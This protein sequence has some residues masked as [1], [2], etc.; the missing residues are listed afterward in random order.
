VLN[1]FGIAKIVEAKDGV[2]STGMSVGT[3]AYMA[4]EQ[5]EG[6]KGRIG[7]TSDLYS[8]GIILYEMVTGQPPFIADTPLAI[9]L[10]HLSDP[11]PLPRTLNPSLP[12]SIERVILKALARVPADR[13]QNGAHLVEALRQALV[14]APTSVETAAPTLAAPIEDKDQAQTVESAR[15]PGARAASPSLAE[16]TVTPAKKIE[17]FWWKAPLWVWG[18]IGGVF[19]LAVVGGILLVGNS[20]PFWSGSAGHITFGFD[21]RVYR[22]EAREEAILE[23][24]SQALDKLSPGAE[25][26]WLNL[27]PDGEWLLL[28]TDRF[29]PECDGWPCLAL[30]SGDLSAGDTIFV[31]WE[32]IHPHGFGAVAS[33]GNL[34]VF[35]RE[36]GPHETDMWALVRSN[37]DWNA[38]LLLTGDSPYTY[39]YWPAI[40]ADGN[41]VVFNCSEVLYGGEG[42]AICEAGTDGT[43]FRV[44]LTPVDGP[45]GTSGAAWHKLLSPHYML[46]GSIIFDAD[47]EEDSNIWRLP[48]GSTEPVQVKARAKF[49][50]EGNPCVLPDGR[51]VTV[52]W[53]DE[54]EGFQIRVTT[55]DGSSHFIIP[56]DEAVDFYIG[57]GE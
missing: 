33:G 42:T 19:L 37:D 30:V 16:P 22:V 55:V 56:T 6:G 43:G 25:D 34:V 54:L 10:K 13:Y 1:D 12:Q 36:G 9:M 49:E 31:D 15:S 41:R 7:P 4:P 39:H 29:E 23:D 48:A 53:F 32:V 50:S 52:K 51:L 20:L 28:N 44:V 38:P 17:P 14:E 24:V 27:S 3:P 11:I 46:D 40:S 21:D 26:D 5:I 2:T 45:T 8:L 18:V 47:W 35:S 57:C